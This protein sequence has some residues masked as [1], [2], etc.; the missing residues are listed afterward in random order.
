MMGM[1]AQGFFHSPSF[2]SPITGMD[3][4]HFAVILHAVQV[5]MRSIQFLSILI[6][7]E[8]ICTLCATKIKHLKFSKSQTRS[9]MSIQLAS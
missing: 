8:I 1:T 7:G 4:E 2:L 9:D 5:V 3:D 6:N